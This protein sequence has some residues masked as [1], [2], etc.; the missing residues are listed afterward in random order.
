MR[1]E[2]IPF[3][4]CLLGSWILLALAP[5]VEAVTYPQLALG[6]GYEAV[7]LIGNQT[8]QEWQ[9]TGQ[10]LQRA[11]QPWAMA[12]APHERLSGFPVS[13]SL[14]DESG[15]QIQQQSLL[16]EGHLSRF[17]SE[18]FENVPENFL[19]TVVI[20]A[21][22]P[23]LLVVLR[24]ETAPSGFQLT[25]LPPQLFPVLFTAHFITA[26]YSSFRLESELTPQRAKAF[27]GQA[28]KD[29]VRKR[30]LRPQ[31]LAS[32]KQD[33]SQ[34]QR[35]GYLSTKVSGRKAET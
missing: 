6:E 30:C 19:G 20:D 11:G 31:A 26:R 25:S 32:N 28:E 5:P 1:K 12:W 18:I 16:F 34:P 7:I 9:G 10:L 17:F 24:V 33:S 8:D 22:E 23:I 4:R 35:K 21:Q 15:K 13:A 3:L 14:L 2:R 29:Y 27:S